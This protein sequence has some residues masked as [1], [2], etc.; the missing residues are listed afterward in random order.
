MIENSIYRIKNTHPNLI[1]F[2]GLK[3]NNPFAP[4]FDVPIWIDQI[5]INLI[6]DI[7]K[8]IKSKEHLYDDWT[9]YNLFLWKENEIFF[10]KKNIANVYVK[11]MEVLNLPVMNDLWINSWVFPQKK[12]MNLKLHTHATHENSYLSGN[13]PLTKNNTTTDYEIPYI[14]VLGGSYECKNKPGKITLF[15]SYLPHS[16]KR[17]DDDE[18]YSIGFDLITNDGMQCFLNNNNNSNDPLHRAIRLF[19]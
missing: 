2:C 7:L 16:V 8:L 10:L 13:I 4:V 19:K 15:P 1:R 12:N 6:D 3:Q 5:D 11:F 17:L 14:S 9:Q 18:R